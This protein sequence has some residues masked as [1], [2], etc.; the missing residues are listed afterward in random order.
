MLSMFVRATGCMY[1]GYVLLWLKVS[2]SQKVPL[3]NF[4]SHGITAYL[5]VD[6]LCFACKLRLSIYQT[7]LIA[8]KEKSTYS[9]VNISFYVQRNHFQTGLIMF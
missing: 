2:K 6:I 7:A 1:A 3:D 8:T 9:S 5:Q 4:S